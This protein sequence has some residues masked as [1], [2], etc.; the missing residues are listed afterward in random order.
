MGIQL[1]DGLG[2]LSWS[3]VSSYEGCPA[4]FEKQYILRLE[5]PVDAHLVLGSGV[6]AAVQAARE[7][8]IAHAL[9]VA[10]ECVEA[11]LKVVRQELGQS[12]REI[13]LHKFED[14]KAVEDRLRLVA[15]VALRDI[16][17]QDEAGDQVLLDVE[18]SI[19]YK[20][21]FDFPFNGKFDAVVGVRKAGVE[22]PLL[23]MVKDLKTASRDSAGVSSAN[24]QQLATYIMPF[25]QAGRGIPW[26]VIERVTTTQN[27]VAAA[28]GYRPTPEELATVKAKIE[29]V[30]AEI[31]SGRFPEIPGMFCQFPHK[32]PSVASFQKTLTP[33]VP[34][35]PRGRGK[36]A[37]GEQPTAEA[38]QA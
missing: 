28:F 38:A 1:P 7:A 3:K 22:K 25:A 9:I 14:E 23:Y 37:Q 17:S 18:R 6:H 16:V 5:C 8:L 2:S 15:G 36:A 33:E 26:A 4:C 27:P 19:S 13:N 24:L 32:L 31:A 10:E 20:D 11:G 30:A 21:V 34:K 12:D 29:R 35:K